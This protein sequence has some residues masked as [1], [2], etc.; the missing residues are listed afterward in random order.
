MPG[1]F[2]AGFNELLNCAEA[3]NFGPA[4]WYEKVLPETV[5]CTCKNRADSDINLDAVKEKI[6][7]IKYLFLLKFHFFLCGIC[8]L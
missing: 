2:H 3:S 8:L 6:D 1:A 7:D 4:H 5:I